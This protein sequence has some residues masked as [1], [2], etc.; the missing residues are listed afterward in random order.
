M[1]EAFEERTFGDL[2]VRIDRNSCIASENCVNL[3]P[4]VFRIGDDGVVTFQVDEPEI[5]R[6]ML[7]ESCS[8]CPVEAL[9]VVDADGTQLVP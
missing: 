6:E 2:T 3:T 8:L 9:H 1:S 4:G 7:I 5:D